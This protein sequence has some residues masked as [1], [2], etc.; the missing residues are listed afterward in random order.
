MGPHAYNKELKRNKC[1]L[2]IT[3]NYVRKVNGK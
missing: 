2:L 1:Y 3:K